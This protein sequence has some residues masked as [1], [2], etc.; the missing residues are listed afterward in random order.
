MGFCFSEQSFIRKIFLFISGFSIKLKMNHSKTESF[1][2]AI[3]RCKSMVL[4]ELSPERKKIVYTG[5]VLFVLICE[6]VLTFGIYI[7]LHDIDNSSIR[8]QMEGISQSILN[9]VNS[10]FEFL[11]YILDVNAAFFRIHGIFLSAE[12]YSDIIQYQSLYLKESV[13]SFIFILKLPYDEKTQFENFCANYIIPDCRITQLNITDIDGNLSYS[14][15]PVTKRA[16]Y[17]PLIF[18]DPPIDSDGSLELFG[19]DLNSVNYE[20][21]TTSVITM[22][23]K[24]GNF[25]LTFRIPLVGQD[26]VNPNSY[27][28]LLNNI[29]YKHINSTDI[30]E[31]YGLVGVAIRLG[32]I[33]NQSIELLNLSVERKDIDLFI[34]DVTN[35]GVVNNTSNNISLLYKESK[36]EYQNIW[37]A[38]QVK[39]S[40]NILEFN[41]SIIGRNWTIFFSYNYNFIETNTNKQEIII[42]SV[43]ASIFFLFDVIILLYK[44][45]K[46]NRKTIEMEKKKNLISQ[47]MLNYVNHEVRNPLNVIKGLVCYIADQM[48]TLYNDNYKKD[49]NVKIINFDIRAYESVLSDLGTVIGACDML[50]HIVTDILD[51]S[52][53][54]SGKLKLDNKVILMSDFMKDLVKTIS[55]KIDEKPAV[56]L[57]LSYNNHLMLYIDQY[58]L[59]Q[60]L[61]NFLT[62]AIKYT[63]KGSILIKIETL[64]DNIRFIIKD[65][66]RGI[67]EEA[68]SRIFQPFHQVVP[69]DA[70]RYGGIGLGLYLCKMLADL[71]GAKIGFE[72]EFGNGSLFWLEFQLKQITA[73]DILELKNNENTISRPAIVLDVVES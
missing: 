21:G 37:F 69:S 55:Q 51:I 26:T 72:S 28:V 24:S 62:N 1:E 3:R 68:K 58:R 38:N 20:E 19:F 6:I 16:F 53:L 56:K 63:D 61:L 31:V 9:R 2:E 44:Y 17:W 41:F 29:V 43:I 32:N 12:N 5:G 7:I 67:K 40:F 52:K 57:E 35:D 46:N 45:F 66:G 33:F 23:L 73:E 42:P 39:P 59:K 10:T 36:V 70:T 18:E 30:K 15:V 14:L 65:T 13:E 8:N 11:E 27:G 64:K 4:E 49:K 48:H 50:E 60:I 71:M 47:Q 22:A 34:F 25:S 54:K